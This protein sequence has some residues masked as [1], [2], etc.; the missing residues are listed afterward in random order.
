MK[1]VSIP[2]GENTLNGKVWKGGPQLLL[3][4]HGFSNSSGIFGGLA[5]MLLPHFTTVALDLP[6]HGSTEWNEKEIL[7]YPALCKMVADLCAEYGVEKLSLLGFSLGGRVALS[8]LV[9]LPEKIRSVT[10]LAP[11]GL[12]TNPIFA[13]ANGSFAGNFVLD[14]LHKHPSRYE[15]LLT[16]LYRRKVFS[17][18]LYQFFLYHLS[19]TTYNDMLRTS[20]KA[21]GKLYPKPAQLRAVFARYDIPVH[22]LMGIHDPVIKLKNG[23]YFAGLFPENVT[24]HKLRKGHRLLT[25][26]VYPEIAQTLLN[27]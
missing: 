27:P 4:F 14:D 8:T 6:G 13:Y 16:M 19:Q 1:P 9:A 15:K 7:D 24:L 25:D 18:K 23:E 26:D 2:V 20:W 10:L 17:E 12:K 11:D 22:L 3:A 5:Q 21:L